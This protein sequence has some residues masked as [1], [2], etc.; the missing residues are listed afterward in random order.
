VE[1]IVG[2]PLPA[3]QLDHRRRRIG[4][5]AGRGVDRQRHAGRLLL[6]AHGRGGKSSNDGAAAGLR[7]RHETIHEYDPLAVAEEE[8]EWEE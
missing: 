4:E 1:R 6:E 3:H 7:V 5:L 2:S 8:E